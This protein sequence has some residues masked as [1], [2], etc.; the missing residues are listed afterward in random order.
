ME[1]GSF[2]VGYLLG[3]P[4]MAFAPTAERPLDMIDGGSTLDNLPEPAR[5]VDRM[6]IWAMA[7]VAAEQLAGAVQHQLAGGWLLIIVIIVVGDDVGT[8]SG[9]AARHAAR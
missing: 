9:G 6:L 4:C 2:L 8:L 1:A 3:L 7:P 5:I